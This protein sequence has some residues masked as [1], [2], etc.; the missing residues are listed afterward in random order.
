MSLQIVGLPGSIDNDIPCTDMA[1]GV[2]TTLNT[3]VDCIDKL[4]DTATSH[5]RVSIVEVMGRLRGYLAVMSG[6]ATGADHIFIREQ[7][8]GRRDL[9]DMLGELQASFDLGQQAGVIVRSEG[10]EFSTG[11]I[12]ESIAN[13]LESR[14][15][16][17]E[18]I[19][20]HLQRGGS[21]TA[22]ERVLAMRLGARAV[23]LL[24]NGNGEPVFAGIRRNVITQSPIADVLAIKNAPSFR[25]TLSRNARACYELAAAP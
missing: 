23:E 3:I 17:R 6:L 10:A 4:R 18:T 8:V 1:I 12:R 14:R 21:P 20:G 2:D 7:P 24:G 11:F 13:L 25:D 16:V 9:L 22:Y 5:K 15:D 19:L